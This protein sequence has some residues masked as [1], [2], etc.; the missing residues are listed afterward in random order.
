MRYLLEERLKLSREEIPKVICT[1]FYR[2][3]NNKIIKKCM[4]TITKNLGKDIQI[5]VR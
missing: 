1:K 5:L 3:N 4:S 2:D